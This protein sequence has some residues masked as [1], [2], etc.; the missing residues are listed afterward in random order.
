MALKNSFLKNYSIMFCKINVRLKT[1]SIFNF[2]FYV[3]KYVFKITFTCKWKKCF[4]KTYDFLIFFCSEKRSTCENSTGGP[5]SPTC[6]RALRMG[7]GWLTAAL[8]SEQW[9]PTQNAPRDRTTK[10]HAPIASV[11]IGRI[12][13]VSSTQT[14]LGN[15]YLGSCIDEERSEIRYLVWIA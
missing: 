14:T 3:F 2:F 1:W 5:G 11:P 10:Q 12:V 9:T 8:S 7:E 13:V 15:G 4:L 6:C